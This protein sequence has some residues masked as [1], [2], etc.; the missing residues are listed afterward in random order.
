MNSTRVFLP[1][2]LVEGLRGVVISVV[3]LSLSVVIF[4]KV[5]V[6]L[7]VLGRPKLACFSEVFTQCGF[8]PWVLG[9]VVMLAKFSC[10]FVGFS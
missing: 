8:L 1:K 2:V 3:V 4:V 9:D 7:L 10:G 5:K 6:M